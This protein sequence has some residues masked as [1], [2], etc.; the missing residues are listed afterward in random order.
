MVKMPQYLTSTYRPA[1]S[2][3]YKTSDSEFK[4]TSS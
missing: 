2:R 3:K 1:I 4:L